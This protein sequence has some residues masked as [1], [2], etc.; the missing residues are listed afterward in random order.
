MDLL[1]IIAIICVVLLLVFG[2]LYFLGR[3]LE[4]K[5]LESQNLLDSM[6]QTATILVI[7]K[8]KMKLKDAGLPKIAY[9]NAPKYMRLMKLPVVKA[10]IGPKVMTLMAEGN[11]YKQLPVK[12]ECKVVLSGIYITKII[13]GGVLDE[14]EIKKRTKAN[15]KA[16]KKEAKKAK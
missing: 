12:S 11:V 7:D 16:A 5:Q 8:K 2:V 9:E 6:A 10:K 4:S 14:K 13:K 15:Q 3:K 1:N